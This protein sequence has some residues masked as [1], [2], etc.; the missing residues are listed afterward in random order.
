MGSERF[1]IAPEVTPGTNPGAG[2]VY[3]E[4]VSIDGGLQNRVVR[5]ASNNT[6]RNPRSAN[7]VGAEQS[8]RMAFEA[9]LGA[10]NA[11][12][13]GI[14]LSTYS[15]PLSITG[16]ISA[17]ASDNSFN[18]TGL[19]T[20]VVPFM[21]VLVENLHSSVN[22]W[23][24]VL[25]KPSNNKIIVATDITGDQSGSG[26]ETVKG[27]YI[28]IGNTLKTYSIELQRPAQS[29]YSL[30]LYQVVNAFNM[31]A[32]VGSLVSGDIS[33][34]GRPQAS[35]GSSSAGTPASA[36]AN[37]ILSP[38]D[39]ITAVFEGS[40]AAALSLTSNIVSAIGFGWNNRFSGVEGLGGFGLRRVEKAIP[41]ITASMRLDIEAAI[42]LATLQKHEQR[43]RTSVAFRMADE[44]GNVQHVT[45]PRCLIGDA[46]AAIQGNEG[47][48]FIELQ[49][50]PEEDANGIA[51]QFDYKA[52]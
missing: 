23:H 2:F 48:R 46:A 18:G 25:D 24:Y 26:D 4:F 30:S 6:N 21:W 28:R 1:A 34:L 52:A 41:E 31:R 32:E 44:A 20:N 29:I 27:S 37:E 47:Q 40:Y 35:L 16:T 43:T 14:M 42:A 45:F 17:T 51:A 15:T 36:S 38:I 8:W 50:I 12:H 3:H 33:F 5:S 7:A 49:L 13:E 11:L 22:G 9:K 10:M 39:D 19:F